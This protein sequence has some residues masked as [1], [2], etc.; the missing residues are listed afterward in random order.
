MNR[1]GSLDQLHEQYPAT[2]TEALAPNSM[3]KRIP[4]E[5]LEQC[6][7]E[8]AALPNLGLPAVPNLVVYELPE[9]GKRYFI[10]GDPAEGNPTSDESAFT[11]VDEDGVEVAVCAGRFQVDTFAHYTAMVASWYG[12]GSGSE[13]AVLVERNNHG[14]AV[15]LWFSENRDN[16]EVASVDWDF[17]TILDGLD[18]RAGWLSSAKGK[19]QMYTYG[20][21]AF[22]DEETVLRSFETYAQLSS[23]SGS[24]LRAPEGERDDRA[25][26]YVLALT[27]VNVGESSGGGWVG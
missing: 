7:V 12:V 1:T 21:E 9:R 6:Y 2:D 15:L 14:H 11:V 8:T 26:S 13:T 24:T 22:R 27:A 25:D 18:G 17:V 5:W 19:K 23:I 16:E 20:T 10:G 4:H 3:D